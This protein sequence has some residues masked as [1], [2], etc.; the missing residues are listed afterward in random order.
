[1]N[2]A[3][4][5]AAVIEQHAASRGFPLETE[6]V[7]LRRIR[8]SLSRQ[9]LRASVGTFFAADK[10]LLGWAIRNQGPLECEFEIVYNDGRT[11]A[12][13][14][15]FQRRATTRPA[16]MAFVRK[17]LRTLCEGAGKGTPVRG[18]VEGPHSFLAHYEI[19]DFASN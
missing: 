1:M 14:Y 19:E 13:E 11:L 4:A 12:G 6:K 9:C 7:G 15:R 8:L 10:V 16:L 5:I 17:T 18:L 2:S 3:I